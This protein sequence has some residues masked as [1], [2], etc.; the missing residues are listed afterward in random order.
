MT[1]FGLSMVCIAGFGV[2]LSS[3]FGFAK[4]LQIENELS[5]KPIAQICCG[6]Y[7]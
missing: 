6:C 3:F 1:F 2:K 4:S 5:I 7:V